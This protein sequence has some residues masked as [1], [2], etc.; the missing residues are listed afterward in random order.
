MGCMGVWVMSTMGTTNTPKFVK[1]RKL[2]LQFL[3]DFTWNDPLATCLI[4]KVYCKFA[5]WIHTLLCH[6]NTLAH[7]AIPASGTKYVNH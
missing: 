2:S 7:Y 1:I 4:I 3:V 6:E 5:I